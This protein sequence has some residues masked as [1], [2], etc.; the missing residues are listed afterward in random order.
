MKSQH[1]PIDPANSYAGWQ[2]G[3]ARAAAGIL[4]GFS[5]LGVLRPAASLASVS[6][7]LS[8][9]GQYQYNSNVF[10]VAGSLPVP[11]TTNDFHRGDS[12]YAYGPALN[13]VERWGQQIWYG[14]ANLTQF[15]Y[16]HFS[17]LTHTEYRLDTGLRWQMGF[18]V[19]GSLEVVR[20]RTMV[21][22]TEVF[23]SQVALNTEQRENAS[24][25][26][27][28]SPRWSVEG[29]GYT[30]S[31]SEP[32][33]EAPDL[34]LSE[35]QTSATLK[36]LG[37]VGLKS[38]VS[39]TYMHGSYSHTNGAALDPSY[40]EKT[41]AFI[42]DYSPT[43]LNTLEGAAGYSRRS[44]ATN[45][46]SLADFTG[47]LA[48]NRQLTAKTSIETKLERNIYS[49]ITNAGSEVDTTAK[50]GIHWQA[51]YKTGLLASYS[52]TYA[53]YPDQG[54]PGQ[55]G[56]GLG[57]SLG[58]ADR[59]DHLQFASLNIIYKARRWLTVRPYFNYQT[60]SSNFRDYGFNSNVVGV[61][62]VADWQKGSGAVIPN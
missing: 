32:L 55:G 57:Q 27:T 56:V 35:S 23:Q 17:Q 47:H 38:G 45:I 53:K 2:G 9:N 36:Y 25:A 52:W 10:D 19:K 6:V 26:F 33:V 4:I 46:D 59:A 16:D 61:Q 14:D 62:L 42:I 7:K 12:Y 28:L 39:V 18:H 54:L 24:V 51:T 48:F 22:F 3:R 13:V 5:L 20:S 44:S 15:Q 37:A 31:V 8:A 41:L 34:R 60:R 21:A 50:V 58:Q 1:G 40:D 29:S 30:R 43:E 11:G 49:Y